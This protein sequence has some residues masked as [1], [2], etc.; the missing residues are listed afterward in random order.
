MCV[1]CVVAAWEGGR[2]GERGLID[3]DMTTHMWITI[4]YYDV[5][6]I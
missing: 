1:S 4:T 3:H 5:T 2:R 6:E